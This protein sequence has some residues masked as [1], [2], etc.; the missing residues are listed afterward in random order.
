MTSP[1]FNFNFT[2][3]KE[4]LFKENKENLTP[5]VQALASLMNSTGVARLFEKEDIHELVKRAQLIF[6]ERDMITDFFNEDILI[7]F[8]FKNEV[9]KLELDTLIS[10]V[11]FEVADVNKNYTAFES[12]AIN[13]PHYKQAA[14]IIATAGGTLNLD[15]SRSNV[16]G[17]KNNLAIDFGNTPDDIPLSHELVEKAEIFA[18]AILKRI[19]GKVFARLKTEFPDKFLE[20]ELRNAPFE[21]PVFNFE[22]LPKEKQEALWKHFWPDMEHFNDPIQREHDIRLIYLAWLWA[23]GFVIDEDINFVHIDFRIKNFDPEELEEQ[24]GTNDLLS[25][26]MLYNLDEILPLL[27]DPGIQKIAQRPWEKLDIYGVKRP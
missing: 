4:K 9:Y 16:S 15:N 2:V 23:N 24:D 1:G 19:P 8:P 7:E 10:Y 20:L 13:I 21:E 17:D 22:T 12:W 3:N 27:K 14:G 6:P 5:Q 18:E 25:L 11:G 26:N